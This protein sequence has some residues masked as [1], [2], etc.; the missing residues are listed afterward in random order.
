MQTLKPNTH[1]IQWP[2]SDHLADCLRAIENHKREIASLTQHLSLTAGMIA[3]EAVLPEK[4]QLSAD[5]ATLTWEMPPAEPPIPDYP[6]PE[7]NDNA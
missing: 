2:W 5:G 3:K 7:K 1:A 4:C 6:D